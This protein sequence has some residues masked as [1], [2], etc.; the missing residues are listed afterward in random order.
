MW[1]QADSPSATARLLGSQQ[2]TVALDG[3][4]NLLV[5]DIGNAPDALTIRSDT[6]NGQYIVADP[7]KTL[8]TTIPGATGDGT[9]LITVPVELVAGTIAVDTRGG[10]DLLTVDLALGSFSNEL[11]Y[12]AG[13]LATVADDSLALTGGGTVANAV[14]DLSGRHHG[15]IDISGNSTIRY[16]GTDE[17]V[18]TIATTDTALNYDTAAEAITVARLGTDMVVTSTAAARL[19]FPTPSGVLTIDGGDIGNDVVHVTGDH[20]L[21]G[22]SLVVRADEIIVEGS[23]STVESGYV[24]LTANRSVQV[25]DAARVQTE[26]GDIRLAGNAGPVAADGYFIGVLVGEHSTISSRHGDILLAGR[27][28]NEA[29]GTASG[30]FHSNQGVHLTGGA[31]VESTGRGPNAGTITINGLGNYQARSNPA[32]EF[33]SP[34]TTVRS[35]D[36]DIEIS[37]I[38]T[39]RREGIVFSEGIVQSTGTGSLAAKIT[40]DGAAGAATRHDHTWGISLSREDTQIS[41]IDGGHYARRNRRD[42][43]RTWCGHPINWSDGRRGHNRHSGHAASRSGYRYPTDSGQLIL[44]PTLDATTIGLGGGH[45]TLNL[46]DVE[47]QKLDDGF[48]SITIGHAT[49]GTGAVDVD[50]SSARS[51]SSTSKTGCL[52]HGECA[53]YPRRCVCSHS[54]SRSGQIAP[55]EPLS[56]RRRSI[57][58]SNTRSTSCSSS[59]PKP[60]RTLVGLCPAEPTCS[61]A[62]STTFGG[63]NKTSSVR[64]A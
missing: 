47:L 45:G 9:Q 34:G 51:G 60:A 7:T 61:S 49:S 40:I 50:S 63:S 62:R 39:D 10:N 35:V 2:T 25:R 1:E 55:S 16:S 42:R 43:D 48:S 8:T 13:D 59:K 64:P 33:S 20:D 53:S 32:V 29:R 54:A 18:S 19:T 22:G 24:E 11:V 30:G 36:G 56:N 28:G 4:G 26:D 6:T 12:T 21:Q 23:I 17:I 57:S 14:F 3:F 44:S 37:G 41:S 58:S 27:G 38:G 31:L 52:S 15:M 46:D 5:T